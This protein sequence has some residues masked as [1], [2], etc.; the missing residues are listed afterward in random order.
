MDADTADPPS[1]CLL[2]SEFRAVYELAAFFAAIPLLPMLRGG[3]GHPV[4]VLPG[5]AAGDG[6]TGPLRAFLSGGGYAAHG[7]NLGRNVGLRPGVV[8]LQLDR[9]WEIRKRYGRKVSLIGWSLGGVFARELAK[10]APEDVRLVITLGSPLRGH[11]K[12]SN[13]WRLYE[14]LAGHTVDH[15]RLHI[16]DSPPP[17]PMTAIFSRTDGIV[18]WPCCMVDDGPDKESVEIEA[19]HCGLGHHPAA[20]YVIADR[21]AQKEGTWA[22]F[23]RGGLRS[24]VYP[25]PWRGMQ[26]TTLRHFGGA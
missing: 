15:V 9:L 11:P 5:F 18:A 10:R 25:D 19:S 4:M 8:A 6:S 23:D 7:L 2:L 1:P 13:A 16:D 12:A 26:R 22:P 24:L 21:L 3:D 14:A 17:V 20:L